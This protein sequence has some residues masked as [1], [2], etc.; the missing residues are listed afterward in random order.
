[1][2]SLRSLRHNPTVR[3]PTIRKYERDHPWLK[4]LRE[5][6]I[7]QLHVAFPSMYFKMIIER[8]KEPY[9]LLY[10]G[11]Y[12]RRISDA[13]DLKAV[14]KKM[15]ESFV[16]DNVYLRNMSF[17]IYYHTYDNTY[18]KSGYHGSISVR[19]KV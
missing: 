4:H 6:L 19:E 5:Y 7:S 15:C 16:K 9:L 10:W 8:T 3:K 12:E 1:M 11:Y 13:E 2:G 17:E 14:L 18:G